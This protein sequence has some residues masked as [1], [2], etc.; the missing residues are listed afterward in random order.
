MKSHHTPLF[1]FLAATLAAGAAL[2]GTLGLLQTKATGAGS[3]P[4]PEEILRLVDENARIT[5]AYLEAS[6][7][8][9]SGNRQMTKTMQIWAEGGDKALVEFTNPGDR[10]TRYLKLGQELWIYSPE[11]EEVVKISGHLLRQGMMGSDFSYQ[12]ALEAERLQDLYDAK[13]IGEEEQAGRTCYVLELTAKP[14]REVSYYRRKVWVSKAELVGVREEL[15]A[16]SGKLL[17]VFTA[18]KVERFGNR[19]YITEATMQNLLKKNSSTRMTI[20][21]IAFD[22]AIPAGTF[23]LQQLTGR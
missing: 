19:F 10:G 12:D 5:T 18:Q 9:Q 8:I 16:Q 2:T 7:L 11:A 1:L 4:A 23:S 22:V 15:Y 20:S 14:G 21:R 13:L 3:A 6:L 17:K